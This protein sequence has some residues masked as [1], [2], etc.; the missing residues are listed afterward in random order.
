MKIVRASPQFSKQS[1]ADKG[2]AISTTIDED[3]DALQEL[4][5]Q[6]DAQAE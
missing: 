5:D 4:V 1:T 3:N 6:I 2:K